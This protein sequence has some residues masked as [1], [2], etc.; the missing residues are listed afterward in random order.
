MTILGGARINFKIV[1]RTIARR[2]P[3]HRKI[4]KLYPYIKETAYRRGRNNYFTLSDEKDIT[5]FLPHRGDYIQQQIILTHSF[6]ELDL[7]Q[8]VKNDI[9]SDSVVID[10]G[11]N[12]G[13]HAVYFGKIA[14]A[15]KIYSFEPNKVAF[16]VLKVN[17]DLNG[18][19][20]K[21]QLYNFALGS[22]SGKAEISIDGRIYDN[23]GYTIL[24]ESV[25]G[26]IE[27]KSLD[28]LNIIE[29]KID[30]IKIDVEGFEIEVL[31]GALLTIQ[32]YLPIIWVESFDDKYISVENFLTENGYVLR[33]SLP[34]SNHIFIPNRLCQ[35]TAYPK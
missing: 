35:N 28:E 7:L 20:T 8:K 30:F 16:D 24:R 34:N 31:K 21:T 6:Y 17:I 14:S 18:L 3:I 13:N 27:I 25:T 22:K 15:R 32:K 10:V 5:F 12:I 1:I 29:N 26:E 33:E 23:L 2:Y 4:K 19:S 11:S 9:N